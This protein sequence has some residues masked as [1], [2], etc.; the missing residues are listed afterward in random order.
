M[1]GNLVAGKRIAQAAG[2]DLGQIEENDLVRKVSVP[3]V[4][5]FTNKSRTELKLHVAAGRCV[6]QLFKSCQPWFILSALWLQHQFL[7]EILQWRAQAT[8]DHVLFMLLNAKVWKTQL[9]IKSAECCASILDTPDLSLS[10]DNFYWQ[11]WGRSHCFLIALTCEDKLEIGQLF[12][13]E[14]RPPAVLFSVVSSCVTI[15]SSLFSSTGNGG[16]NSAIT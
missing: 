3:E 13:V 5:I 10:S 6:I 14:M 16:A 8:P 15:E 2:R 11:L 9:Y 1:V 12:Q 7:A 4:L